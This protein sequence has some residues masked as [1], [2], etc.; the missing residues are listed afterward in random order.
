MFTFTYCFLSNTALQWTN[1]LFLFRKTKQ[2]ITLLYS[3]YLAL[4][5]NMQITQA[6]CFTLQ[7]VRFKIY[8]TFLGHFLTSLRNVVIMGCFE[9]MYDSI[10]HFQDNTEKNE[11][12]TQYYERNLVTN[13][14][15]LVLNSWTVHYLN[16]DNSYYSLI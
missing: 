16:L 7:K 13:K 2:N 12:E 6:S 10:S 14:T 8:G 15:N 4:K 3:T 1:S 11:T 5:Q 9:K